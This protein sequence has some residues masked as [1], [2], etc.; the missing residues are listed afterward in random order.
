MG[1]TG[2]TCLQILE[3]R[4]DLALWA[5]AAWPRICVDEELAEEEIGGVHLPARITFRH[6]AAASPNTCMR[7]NEAITNLKNKI[8]LGI[9]T[10]LNE[11]L[12]R[13]KLLYAVLF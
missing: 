1:T 9:W 7:V 13:K 2:E 5:K 12:I 10:I 11:L 3:V 6:G 8:N 4:G